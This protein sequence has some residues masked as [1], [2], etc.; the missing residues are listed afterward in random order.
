M[1]EK[2]TAKEAITDYMRAIESGKPSKDSDRALYKF[3]QSVY[4]SGGNNWQKGWE[5]HHKQTA[6]SD[7]E[8]SVI[9]NMIL[10]NQDAMLERLILE[11]PEQQALSNLP[12]YVKEKSKQA[13]EPPK[14]KKPQAPERGSSIA[15]WLDYYHAMQKAN[16]KITF[17]D[18]N[19][20]SG[21]SA[22][23]FK[24]EHGRYKLERGI[25]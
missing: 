25:D 17:K 22:N 23:T 20:L 4:R 14:P 10:P 19:K 15:V 8:M 5:L 16:Y 9:E 21:Y 12:D 7:L 1:A 18:L 2:R 13:A 3:L 6:P 11:M 24:Q